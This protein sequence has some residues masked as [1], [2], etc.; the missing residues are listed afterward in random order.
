MFDPKSAQPK[1]AMGSGAVSGAQPTT[2]YFGK[3]A[4]ED[5]VSHALATSWNHGISLF[6]NATCMF[7]KQ[8]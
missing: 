1:A 7:L 5:N 4:L 3:S 2:N 8:R 6:F